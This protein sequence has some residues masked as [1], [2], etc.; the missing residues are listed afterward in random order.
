M[1]NINIFQ[2]KH[3]QF[4]TKNKK[5]VNN[6][7]LNLNDV[8]NGFASIS[9][10]KPDEFI[11]QTFSK[12]LM[13][14]LDEN[15]EYFMRSEEITSFLDEEKTNVPSKIINYNGLCQLHYYLT[16]ISFYGSLCYTLACLLD[17]LFKLK[18]IEKKSFL[19]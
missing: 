4:Y 6:L 14:N 3:F 9:T 10:V 16:I 11:N 13:S 2:E 19:I 8:L 12:A 17:R 5:P 7:L 1:I 15:Q 18:V